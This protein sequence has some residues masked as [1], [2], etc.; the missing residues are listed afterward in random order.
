MIRD[1]VRVIAADA[2][3][4]EVMLMEENGYRFVQA[5]AVKTETGYDIY[6]TFAI[7]YTFKHL[8]VELP[9]G[10]S[11]VSISH[12][13]KPAFLYENEIH[14]MF[15]INIEKISL[16]FHGKLYRLGQETP[17]K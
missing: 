12:I 13:Y 7:D 14:D 3:V 2:I 17:Y 15:G 9:F 5:H 11:I 8:K 10:E 16:D 6:Y 1:E 4:T